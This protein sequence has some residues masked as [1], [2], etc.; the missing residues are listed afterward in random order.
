[1]AST[2]Q[3]QLTETADCDA[4]ILIDTM[5]K[6]SNSQ[7]M[8]ND[9][10]SSLGPESDSDSNLDS[11]LEVIEGK[12]QFDHSPLLDYDTSWFRHRRDRP[13]VGGMDEI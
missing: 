6:D 3:D 2:F 8:H 4:T 5:D 12:Y 11:D 9:I 1:M 10:S 13:R 7:A